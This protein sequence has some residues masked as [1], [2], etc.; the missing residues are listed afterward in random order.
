MVKPQI[1]TTKHRVAAV[2][3]A[4]ISTTVWIDPCSKDTR[5][6]Q[7]MAEKWI[8]STLLLSFY[9]LIHSQQCKTQMKWRCSLSLCLS[10]PKHSLSRSLKV[11][12]HFSIVQVFVESA[13][14]IANG[15]S[16]LHTHV[17][18]FFR[19]Y[20]QSSKRPSLN[21]IMLRMSLNSRI[22]LWN[23]TTSTTTVA[24]VTMERM[25]KGNFLWWDENRERIEN[26]ISPRS[27]LNWHTGKENTIYALLFRSFECALNRNSNRKRSHTL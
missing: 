27:D 7:V 8:N 11:D 4:V 3:T 25:T 2:V 9:T 14:K 18:I 17:D 19:D 13:T 20:R 1:H 21:E 12:K 16:M 26:N 23:W 22:I 5:N 6:C 15:T 24:S 10:F